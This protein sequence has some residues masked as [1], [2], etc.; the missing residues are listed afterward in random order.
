MTLTGPRVDSVELI[1]IS[2]CV[3]SL[4]VDFESRVRQ[5]HL[6]TFLKSRYKFT[7]SALS[8]HNLGGIRGMYAHVLSCER[9][10]LVVLGCGGLIIAG[11]RLAN[12]LALGRVRPATQ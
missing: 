2:F 9:H 5:C 1:H 3:P 11:K 7:F 6:N 8:S 4:G 10:C 12:V